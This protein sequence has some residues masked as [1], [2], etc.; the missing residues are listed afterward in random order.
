MHKLATRIQPGKGPTPHPAKALRC[1]AATL[2]GR[3]APGPAEPL[4][5]E[6]SERLLHELRM[7]QLELELQNLELRQAQEA[8]ESSRKRY[9]DLYDHAP[10]G[11][12]TLNKAG[13][14]LEANLTA[15]TLLGLSR[16]ELHRQPITRFILPEDQDIYYLHRI[17]QMQNGPVRSGRCEL[18]LSRK[19][20]PPF[21]ARLEG[22]AASDSEAGVG[23][24]RVAISDITA[25]KDLGHAQ[26]E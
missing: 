18:R 26:A 9:V 14:I 15:A 17:R 7:H 8:L 4:G 3:L 11:Y 10:V 25:W 12:L 1:K 16:Q 22:V 23:G 19:D 13:L 5:S 21:W 24:C 6:A 20:A 2:L